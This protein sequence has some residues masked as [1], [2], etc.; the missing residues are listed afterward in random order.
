MFDREQNP[1]E[2][3]QTISVIVDK[4]RILSGDYEET[5]NA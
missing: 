2:L 1:D 3:N 4:Q 5:K